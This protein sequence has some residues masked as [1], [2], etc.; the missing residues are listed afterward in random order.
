MDLITSSDNFKKKSNRNA[1]VQ[2][3]RD[4]ANAIRFLS[5]DMVNQANSGHPGAPLGLADVATVL[6]KNHLRFFANEPQWQNRDR[7]VLSNGHA[8]AL[9][10]SLL[11]L[12][13]YEDCSL[14]DLKNF[15]QID[16]KTAGHP[17]YALLK[18]VETSTGPLGQGLANA[19]GMALGQKILKEC[20]QEEVS[21]INHKTYV[22]VGDGCLEEGISY[23][24]TSLAGHHKL[25]DLIVLWDNNQITIDGPIS[26]AR[27]ED[28]HQR[29]ESIGWKVLS[30]D[31]HDPE[32][33]DSA[34]QKAQH[35]DQPVFIDCRTIIAKGCPSLEGS[36]KAHGSP[37]GA[38]KRQEMAK[39]LKWENAPFEIPQTVLSAW[40]E[41][42]KQYKNEFISWKAQFDSSK[43]IKSFY[44]PSSS[45]DTQKDSLILLKQS[46][47]KIKEEATR[48]TLKSFLD[49]IHLNRT[50]GGSADLTPSNNTQREND[51]HYIHYGI[52]EHAMGAIMNGLS[53]YGFTP[54]G[55]TFLVFSDYMK[56]PIRLASLMKIPTKF[57]FTHDSFWVGED[58]PTHQP[59][60]QIESLRMIPNLD[61]LRPADAI[62]AIECCELVFGDKYNPHAL[63]LSRQKLPLLRK[64]ISENKSAK[65]G[66]ILQDSEN[67]GIILMATGS[68]VSLAIEIAQTLKKS[69]RIVSMPCR[70]LFDRQS[71][72]Y[73]QSVLP[74]GVLTIAIE[75]GSPNGWYKYADHVFGLEDFGH[76]GKGEDVAEKMKFTAEYLKKEISR[77]LNFPY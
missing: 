49:S 28:M 64:D 10:Y 8:S 31:G 6:F 40:R 3:L 7:F 77:L 75:A 42:G 33:I 34:L 30:C 46:K 2:N 5:V 26:L 14:D 20:A 60:E 62:E 58:G 13:G 22:F 74:Q 63:L 50:V 17:E 71:E 29:F 76:S 47:L 27:S 19:V 55:G 72:S 38:E 18:G 37:L 69:I 70:E 25:K 73:K 66:Y 48:Q 61:V 16:S 35:S 53:L 41:I 68:E 67:P 59:I 54:Y 11:Y 52:R 56:A 57:I 21:L 43:I 4:L 9:L 15:R 39:N 23:E 1:K 65:G 45:L 51:L 32:E 12:T 36:E 24:A 44:N